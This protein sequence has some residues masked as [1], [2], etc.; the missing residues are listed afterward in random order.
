[1]TYRRDILDVVDFPTRTHSRPELVAALRDIN[2][3]QGMS[4]PAGG[5]WEGED[6]G[7]HKSDG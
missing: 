5:Y 7:E 2:G 3:G 6:M 4:K 1:M